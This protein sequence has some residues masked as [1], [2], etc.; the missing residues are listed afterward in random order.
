MGTAKPRKPAENAL[1]AQAK[2]PIED[3]RARIERI[4]RAVA[5]GTYAPDPLE[6]SQAIIRKSILP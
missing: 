5:E 1:P 3:R 2:A 6:V 4:R